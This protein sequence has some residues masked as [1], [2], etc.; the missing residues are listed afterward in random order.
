VASFTSRV[1]L[2]PY[3][4]SAVLSFVT[5]PGMEADKLNP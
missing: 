2:M 1:K 4:F 3:F 5:K